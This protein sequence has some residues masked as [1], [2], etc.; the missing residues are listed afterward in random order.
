M[1][2]SCIAVCLSQNLA[3]AADATIAEAARMTPVRSSWSR[4][5]ELMEE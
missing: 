2:S 5:K 3:A 1:P 4:T